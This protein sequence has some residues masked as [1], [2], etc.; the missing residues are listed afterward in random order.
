M[1]ALSLEHL[2]P[3]PGVPAGRPPDM[4]KS[5]RAGCADGRGEGLAGR[6]NAASRGVALRRRIVEPDNH[7]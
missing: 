1:V 4:K 2:T 3:Y 5:C 6:G 7:S